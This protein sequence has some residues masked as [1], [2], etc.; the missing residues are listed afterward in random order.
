M[1]KESERSVSG[2]RRVEE[3]LAGDYWMETINA[4]DTMRI[5]DLH[6]NQAVDTPTIPPPIMTMS[7]LA[8]ICVGGL[9]GSLHVAAT[10]VSVMNEWYRNP[11]HQ[12][13]NADDN[14]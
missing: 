7:A 14:A 4:G 5:T 3:V 11:R 8:G 12:R 6:G 10:L 1:L 9:S 2:A 13:T